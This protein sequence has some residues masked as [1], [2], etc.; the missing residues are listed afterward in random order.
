MPTN[1]EFQTFKGIKHGV[2]KLYYT[3]RN[4]IAEVSGELWS[5]QNG[6]VE[7]KLHPLMNGQSKSA[8]SRSI[9]QQTHPGEL[10]DRFGDAKT[11]TQSNIPRRLHFW[12]KMPIDGRIP[13][14]N[15][16]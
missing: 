8:A 1:I 13:A 14:G 5:S 4:G 3:E 16:P 11:A 10:R 7:C 6:V 9:E 12:R 2:F 15:A